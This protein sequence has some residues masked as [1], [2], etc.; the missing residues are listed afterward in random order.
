MVQSHR[1][2]GK[3][4]QTVVATLGRLDALNDHLRTTGTGFEQTDHRN[5]GEIADV[6][7]QARDM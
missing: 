3:P 6:G 5:A 7:D 4:R 1:I 2:N